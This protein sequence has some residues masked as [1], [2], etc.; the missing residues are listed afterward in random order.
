M[1]LASLCLSG[2]TVHTRG[3]PRPGRCPSP[4]TRATQKGASGEPFFCPSAMHSLNQVGFL[5]PNKASK[6]CHLTPQI[7][8]R[9]KDSTSPVTP[10]WALA[11]VVPQNSS[12]VTTAPLAPPPAPRAHAEPEG[13]RISWVAPAP[14]CS[15]GRTLP[16]WPAQHLVL[17]LTLHNEQRLIDTTMRPVWFVALGEDLGSGPH[18]RFASGLLN[19]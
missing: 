2:P 11:T 17:G 3:L 13:G 9:D 6:S 12:V 19:T 18:G 8:R 15:P 7:S 16:L 14:S 5:C 10:S 1:G 4:R